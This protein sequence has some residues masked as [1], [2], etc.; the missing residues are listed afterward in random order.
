MCLLVHG[1]QGVQ[2]VYSTWQQDR[3]GRSPVCSR[4][5]SMLRLMLLLALEGRADWLQ[6]E[7]HQGS[8]LSRIESSQIV[9]DGSTR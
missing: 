3:P 4:L 8:K 7:L 5:A 1:V 6:E 9:E 2:W